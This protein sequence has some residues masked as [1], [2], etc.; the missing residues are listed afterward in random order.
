M[1]E[2]TNLWDIRKLIKKVDQNWCFINKLECFGWWQN[3]R[4]INMNIQKFNVYCFIW[5]FK[6]ESRH[7]CLTLQDQTLGVVTS[8]HVKV[9]IPVTYMEVF[10]SLIFFFS[11]SYFGQNQ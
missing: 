3:P 9:I 8:E 1:T 5:E 4:S 6:N 11:F 2:S 10:S 7:F